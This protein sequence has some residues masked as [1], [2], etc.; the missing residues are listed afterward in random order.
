MDRN[1]SHVLLVFVS[2]W[3]VLLT[4][5]G[6]FAVGVKE[7][8][9]DG[10]SVSWADC[11]AALIQKIFNSTTLP[12]KAEPD[13]VE[14]VLSYEMSG[15]PSP[16]AGVS[17]NGSAG[18]PPY[19]WRNGLQRLTWNISSPFISLNS[20]VLYSFNT[21]GNAP[22]NYPP[23]PAAPGHPT[24]ASPGFASF[25]AR[26]RTLVLYHNGHETA[27]C[28]PNYD[29][30]V[31]HFNELGYDV[32]ELMMPLIGCNQA[33][34]R[35]FSLSCPCIWYHIIRTVYFGLVLFVSFCFIIS[36]RE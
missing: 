3:V 7:T 5:T 29:G 22:A 8:Y 34:V 33:C 12:Q 32:M 26:G 13:S 16:G 28:T 1:A 2:A 6:A 11:R 30:V 18:T 10:E 36:S 14:E 24:P 23:P 4:S 21:S 25:T 17:P 20:T 9:C 19:G 31:D 27:D 35:S 15:W